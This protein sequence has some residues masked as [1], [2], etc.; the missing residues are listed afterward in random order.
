MEK[1]IVKCTLE[2]VVDSLESTAKDFAGIDF[3][4]SDFYFGITNNIER[5]EREH[6][7]TFLISFNVVNDESAKQIERIM[8]Q[9]GFT[10]GKVANGASDGSTFVYL[11]LITPDTIQL[12]N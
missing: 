7:A 11:Y 9:K 12:E 10:T 3:V 8:N 4:A 1:K 6:N 5:R 2:Q